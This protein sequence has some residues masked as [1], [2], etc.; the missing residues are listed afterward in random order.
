MTEQQTCPGCAGARG[1]E[2]TEHSVETDG[3]GWQ[4]PVRRTFW[5]PCTVCAG[6]GV[7]HQ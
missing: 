7:V 3:Q 6:L 1:T 5:S 2:K 4:E